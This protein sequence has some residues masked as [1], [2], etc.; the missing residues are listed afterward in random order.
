MKR[1]PQ[2]AFLI[3]SNS[4]GHR[5]CHTSLCHICIRRSLLWKETYNMHFSLLPTLEGTDGVI[6]LFVIYTYVG[7][8]YDKET[9][10]MHFSTRQGVWRAQT[11]LPH[12]TWPPVLCLSVTYIYIYVSFMTKKPTICFS[13]G[14]T[15]IWFNRHDLLSC[16]SLSFIYLR[17]FYDKETYNMLFSRAQTHLPHS[18]WPPILC[19]S[20]IYIYR[21]LLWQ[22]DL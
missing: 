9:Y 4:L 11:H 1:D 2:Y 8:F 13:R 6:R 10:N 15:R 17:L 5:R 12:S 16:V 3:T 19:L 20:V 7:L 21:S 18:R 14:H 22:R